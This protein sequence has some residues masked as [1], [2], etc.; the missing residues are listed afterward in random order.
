VAKNNSEFVK[1]LNEELRKLNSD[2]M[3]YEEDM[4][5]QFQA[6][7][8]TWNATN[9][10]QRHKLSKSIVQFHGDV[11]SLL[12]WGGINHAAIT[13]ILKKHDK[14]LDGF[15]MKRLYLES[16]VQQPFYSTDLLERL[17][18]SCESKINELDPSLAVD[19]KK[20]NLDQMPDDNDQ[21]LKKMLYAIRT[22]KD[23]GDNAHTPSTVFSLSKTASDKIVAP[24]AQH[25]R[26]RSEE[27]DRQ[28]KLAKND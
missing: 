5:I 16:A 1:L 21:S 9:P 2:F 20:E 18:R 4:V 3:N 25:K 10:P 27:G 19:T 15:P 8:S 28:T 6:L 14:I 11:I 12:H 17:A 22:W 13:K 7:E 26:G 23:L 24:P